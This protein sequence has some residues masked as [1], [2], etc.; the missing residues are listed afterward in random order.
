MYRSWNNRVSFTFNNQEGVRNMYDWVIVFHAFLC[1]LIA[2]YAALWFVCDVLANDAPIAEGMIFLKM[3]M[4]V[5]IYVCVVLLSMLL[6]G[7]PAVANW[8]ESKQ[9][10]KSCKIKLL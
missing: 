1:H 4:F 9:K 8:I 6:T 3:M 10:L 7:F 2:C 5:L